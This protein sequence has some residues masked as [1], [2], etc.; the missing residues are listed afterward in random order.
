MFSST[1]LVVQWLRLRH[2]S[3]GTQVQYLSRELRSHMPCQ[4]FYFLILIKK[5][6]L[7]QTWKRKKLSDSEGGDSQILPNLVGS[8]PLITVSWE[9]QELLGCVN[10]SQASLLMIPASKIWSLHSLPCPHLTW[11]SSIE[12]L[13]SPPTLVSGQLPKHIPWPSLA[14]P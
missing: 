1:S 4:K 9:T 8:K 12:L 5:K 10:C 3:L 14:H 7:S 13:A 6:F 2:P 11:H